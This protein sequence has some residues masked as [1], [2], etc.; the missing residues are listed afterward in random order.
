[1]FTLKQ[2]SDAF[3]TFQNQ[4]FAT[5]RRDFLKDVTEKMRR[6]AGCKTSEFFFVGLR[7]KLARFFA[8]RVGTIS[9]GNHTTDGGHFFVGAKLFEKNLQFDDDVFMQLYGLSWQRAASYRKQPA[10]ISAL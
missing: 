10:V 4:F 5:F 1:M 8:T 2:E 7:T 6:Q 3:L 9:A